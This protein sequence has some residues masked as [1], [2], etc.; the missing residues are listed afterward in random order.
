MKQR[1]T[2][3][4]LFLTI[5]TYSQS[6]DRVAVIDTDFIVK[7][8]PEYQEA[9]KELKKRAAEWDNTIEKR[10]KEIKDLKEELNV[11]RPLLTQQLIDEK[12]EDIT[13]LEKE[14][15]KFQQEKYG[16]EGDY[17]VQKINLV[18]P[19]QD[20]IFTIINDLGIKKKFG[21]VIDKSDK[22]A[23]LYTDKKVEISDLVIRELEKSRNKSK[24]TKAE[25]KQLEEQEK[26]QEA[27]EKQ[28]TKRELLAERQKEIEAQRDDEIINQ[29]KA[30]NPTAFETPQ[31]KQQRIVKEKQEALKKQ[32][33]EIKRIQEEKIAQ[34]KKKIEDQKLALQKQKEEIAAQQ[35]KALEKQKIL[36]QQQAEKQEELKRKQLLKKIELEK[37]REQKLA[38]RQKVLLQRK[39]ELDDK[40]AKALKEKE[41]IKEKMLQEKKN[42]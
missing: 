19:I 28:Q 14:L 15:V 26:Q 32:Q 37:I 2:I 30:K 38:E 5:A 42:K 16:P 10:K 40:K 29:Y 36:Q 6:K 23:I 20:Q 25:I 27:Q 34:Q 4:F 33:E 9:Q 1:F 12:M 22:N 31:E 8:T 18:K 24:L 3:L 39:K 17:F 21:V 35:Q 11:E 13:I 41:A 7:K